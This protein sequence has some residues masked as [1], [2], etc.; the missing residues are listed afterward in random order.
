MRTTQNS[1][2]DELRIFVDNSNLWI[3]GMKVAARAAGLETEQD[4]R[5]RIFPSKLHQLICNGR[6]ATFAKLW[7]SI[8]PPN[9]A[10]WDKIGE[11]FEVDVSK[12]SS[13]TNRE[14]Q[15]DVKIGHCAGRHLERVV[16]N[17]LQLNTVFVIVSGDGDFKDTVEEIIKEGI[18]VE[19]W[20]WRSSLSEGIRSI[21]DD[22]LEVHYLDKYIQQVGFIEQTFKINAQKIPVDRT[23]IFPRPLRSNEH[24]GIICA[25]MSE[26]QVPSYR[27][28]SR[29]GL[30]DAVLDARAR[31][32][33]VLDAVFSW[34]EY[35]DGHRDAD[36]S[37]TVSNHY[38]R[39]EE[40][41]PLPRATP[42]SIVEDEWT[43]PNVSRNRRQQRIPSQSC[44]YRIHCQNFPDCSFIHTRD[45]AEY[46]RTFGPKKL[47]KVKMCLNEICPFHN[48]PERCNHAHSE[49]DLFCPT[50]QEKGHKKNIH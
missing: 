17:H 27:Y 4:P 8:P 44:R 33:G 36:L 50:C 35:R 15:V 18:R 37:L 16:A 11:I 28:E 10:L 31:F 29:E 13:W 39:I 22:L 19:V 1:M 21:E 30:A 45:D 14:K 38:N 41:V 42:P 6:R 3:E 47:R 49:E 5:W 7:G 24:N 26:L 48:R 46:L 34:K 25:W 40:N 9:P 23:I 20:S 32:N 2:D 43:D 12:R